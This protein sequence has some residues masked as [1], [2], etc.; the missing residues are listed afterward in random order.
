M[1]GDKPFITDEGHYIL[2]LHIG[3]IARPIDYAK[4]RFAL[5]LLG[6]WKQVCFLN[7]ANAVLWRIRHGL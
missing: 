2:D 6:S 7:M 3:R 5:L 1:V 4:E